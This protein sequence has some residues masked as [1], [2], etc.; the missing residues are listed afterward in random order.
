MMD[1]MNES[2]ICKLDLPLNCH[3]FLTVFWEY[4]FVKYDYQINICTH[5]HTE[6]YSRV[7]H[8]TLNCCVG[9]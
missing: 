8:R 2:D 9:L 7:I 3:T 1:A 4:H 5:T 6:V